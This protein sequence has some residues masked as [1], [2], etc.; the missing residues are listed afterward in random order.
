MAQKN[1]SPYC[2][3]AARTLLTQL[4]RLTEQ[5]DGAKK[6]EDVECV[7]QMR[8][9]SRRLRSALP[10][11]K[12]C[13]PKSFKKWRKEI[14]AVTKV[15]GAARDLDVQILFLEDFLKN[16]SEEKRKKG[17]ARL[18]LRQ[19]QKRDQQQ[20]QV[21]KAIDDFQANII[22]N[23]IINV[24]RKIIGQSRLKKISE[25]VKTINPV[26][27][28]LI[29]R[30]LA[31]VLSYEDFIYHPEN[32]TQLHN[33]RIACKRL[34]YTLELLLPLYKPKLNTPIK[35][36]KNLQSLLGEIHDCDV[37]NEYIPIFI[38]EERERT[39]Q[40][41]GHTRTFGSIRQGIE[42]LNTAQ[43]KRRNEIY[44]QFIKEWENL[45]VEKLWQSL[46]DIVMLKSAVNKN[47]QMSKSKI[48]SVR[49]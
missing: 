40:Y 20:K 34:R 42:F 38:E 5:M 1:D 35:T 27:Q 15:L 13:F 41:Y 3:F 46:R 31:E 22:I 49:D 29:C 37:W 23:D 8:V 28:Q 6:A 47:M 10:V 14:R 17:V 48:E 30:E 18:L 36:I 45:K 11:F 33:L 2:V 7:H 24:A 16:I 4:N 44:H 39:R 9:A 19:Q 12:D 25:K 21:V 43:K 26:I 32:M